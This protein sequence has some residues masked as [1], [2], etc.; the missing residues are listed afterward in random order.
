MHISKCSISVSLMWQKTHTY[1]HT[2]KPTWSRADLFWLI[3]LEGLVHGKMALVASKPALRQ[4]YQ[5]KAM[6][7]KRFYLMAVR[8]REK[9]KLQKGGT[10]PQVHDS[11]PTFFYQAS[12]SVSIPFQKCHQMMILSVD[13]STDKV[14]AF[15][16]QSLP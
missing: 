11:W 16:T 2:H 4:K 5:R 6:T 10:R 1:T 8:S 12:P 9:S 7:E 15:L 13:T 14:K 3:V